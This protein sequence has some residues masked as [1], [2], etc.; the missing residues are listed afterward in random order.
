M[1]IPDISIILPVFNTE[2]YLSSC[3]D[4]LL[5]QTFQHL[6][7][8]AVDDGSTDSSGHILD[9]YALQDKRLRVYHQANSGPATAR[10]K[11]LD[12][13]QGRYIMFCDADDRYEP[14][15]CEKMFQAMQTE[16]P[17][18]AMCNAFV[19]VVDRAESFPVDVIY[20][21]KSGNVPMNDVLKVSLGAFLW[22]KIFRKDLIDRYALRFPDGYRADDSAFCRCYLMVSQRAT[23][24]EEKLYHYLVRSGSIMDEWDKKVNYKDVFAVV[25]AIEYVYEF[26]MK[27]AIFMKNERVFQELYYKYVCFAWQTLPSRYRAEFLE[28][29]RAFLFRIKV[30]KWYFSRARQFFRSIESQHYSQ[31]RRLMESDQSQWVIYLRVWKYRLLT[32]LTSGKT[33][34]KYRRK[35]IKNSI[36]FNGIGH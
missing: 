36:L 5:G 23:F 7:I 6:E 29:V 2:K 11:G 12:A 22:N 18:F 3:L 31:T 27:H 32:C 8:L 1:T 33:R 28:Y 24:L 21:Q 35:L 14:Q 19:E 13:A 26:L 17:D 30:R 15:M 25:Y 34:K 16:S 20:S 4:S 10:N 9:D